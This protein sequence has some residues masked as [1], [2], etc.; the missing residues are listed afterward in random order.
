MISVLFCLTGLRENRRHPAA[1]LVHGA[2]ALNNAFRSW[3]RKEVRPNFIQFIILSI[4]YLVY[5]WI[6]YLIFFFINLGFR[7]TWNRNSR[8]HQYSNTC[9]RP[10]QGDSI[11]WGRQ[12]LAEKDFISVFSVVICFLT[13][14]LKRAHILWQDIFQQNI[15]RTGP[16][17]PGSPLSK[18]PLTASQNS[19]RPPGKKKGPKSKE[20]VGSLPPAGTKKQSQKS[21]LK[22]EAGE[23]DL[24]EIHTKHTL[25]KF[26]PGKSKSRN[27][28]TAVILV[29]VFVCLFEYFSLSCSVSSIFQ[30]DMPLDELGGK[31]NKSK[32]KLVLTNG[33]I[34]GYV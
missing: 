29:G 31:L 9:E 28:V 3:T 34:Q 6:K 26:N 14:Q 32:L 12:L 17:F 25:K 18:A 23:L 15:G 24:I 13:D 20:V 33:K 30:L 5:W 27:K 4:Y 21:L 7:W 16:P 1:Y 19:G 22:A 8:N 11:G 2:K 10:C